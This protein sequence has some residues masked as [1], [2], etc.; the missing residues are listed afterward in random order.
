MAAAD[1]L[2]NLTNAFKEYKWHNSHAIPL[3]VQLGISRLEIP[4]DLQISSSNI[5]SDISISAQIISNQMVKGDV[6]LLA[7]S[8]LPFSYI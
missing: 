3:E 7:D 1:S 4:T 2:Q 6:V 8:T 5:P